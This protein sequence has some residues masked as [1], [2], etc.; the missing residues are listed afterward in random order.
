VVTI[1]AGDGLG[2]GVVWS[3]D[4]L[5]VTDAHVVGQ[6][7][8][9]LVDFADGRQVTGVVQAT[10]ELSDL[11][12]V[13]AD[14]TGL[15]P[16]TFGAARPAV[17]SLVIA[18][19]SPLGLTK[20]VTTGVVSGEGRELP[21]SSP[22]GHPIVDLLQTDASISP[23]N[24]GGALVDGAGKVIGIAEAYLPPQEGA[25]SIG[26]VT[27][28]ATV[29]AVV[30]Q[31]VATGHATHAYIGL[32]T[33]PLTSQVRQQ[34][35]TAAQTGTVVLA[36]TPGGP[37]ASAGLE[38]GDVIIAVDGQA[39]EAP[40]D[41]VADVRSHAPGDT[42]TVAYYRGATSRNAAVRLTDVPTS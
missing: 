38:R 20:S 7:T 33:A 16:A 37:A 15:T 42:V 31:L 30:Q 39:V 19:G 18:I 10:D 32:Q 23:G 2:S 22:G 1:E 14:R 35:G 26:F 29:V 34:L 36:L 41:L 13:K 21:A 5:I 9:V 6:S 40:E 12:V 25:V 8:Q 24:S 17:G 27:P 11:A 3:A 4:G 28:S